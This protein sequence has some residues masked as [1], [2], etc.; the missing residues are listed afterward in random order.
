MIKLGFHSFLSCGEILLL[1]KN[2][3]VFFLA[4][5]SF[6]SQNQPYEAVSLV[7]VQ[8]HLM[9]P[10]GLSHRLWRTAA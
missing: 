1:F 4:R 10:F 5:F 9:G 3:Q 6:C 8:I 2:Q 7:T